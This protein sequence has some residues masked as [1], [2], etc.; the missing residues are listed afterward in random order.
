MKRGAGGQGLVEYLAGSGG[1]YDRLDALILAT[2][3]FALG[4]WLLG[5]E[6]FVP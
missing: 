1:F 3:V 5:F 2:P 4:L 6:N